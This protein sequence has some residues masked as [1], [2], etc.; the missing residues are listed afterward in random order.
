MLSAV[1]APATRFLSERSETKGVPSVIV[2]RRRRGGRR[3]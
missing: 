3:L 2:V 1:I